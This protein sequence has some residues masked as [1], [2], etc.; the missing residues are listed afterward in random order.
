MATV[1]LTPIPVGMDFKEFTNK[2]LDFVAVRYIPKTYKEKKL[3]AKMLLG[4]IGQD[5][6]LTEKITTEL[7]SDYLLFRAS[8]V[9][10][11]ASN[12]SR[13]N[14][15]AQWNWGQKVLDL[16]SNPVARLGRL[17]HTTA[18]QYTPP[19]HDVLKVLAATTGQDRIIIELYLQTA[20]R[21]AEIF[22][23]KWDDVN[24]ERRT[25]TLKTRKSR[26]GSWKPRTVA[27]TQRMADSLKKIWDTRKFP[28]V[29][30][31]FVDLR[32]G[33]HYGQPYSVR[34]LML[35]IL[36]NKVKV[37]PFGFHALRRFVATTLNDNPK[38]RTKFIQEL[39]GHS[40]QSTTERYLANI[41]SDG[42]AGAEIM[43]EVILGLSNIT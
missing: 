37:K 6:I 30:N 41:V 21:R 15:L 1:K 32:E 36:C 23:L 13:K 35:K 9:S 20:A 24:L 38:I 14:L 7:I 22:N 26:D 25:V 33:P 11:H 28:D 19:E 42:H 18:N 27:I 12:R 16:P 2:Y 39:L 10:N 34:R 29:P 4:F 17:P 43:D 31:V 5:D 3:E 40:S 8:A